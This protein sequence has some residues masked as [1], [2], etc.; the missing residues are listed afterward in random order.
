MELNRKTKPRFFGPMVVVR[1]NR[2]GA[3]ILA[4]LDGAV[5]KLSY[6]AFRVIPYHAR[7]RATI[8]VTKIVRMTEEELD[9]MAKDSEDADTDWEEE[10]RA[11]P[12]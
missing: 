12:A 10:A 5:S 4:E 2:G 7:S 8:P 3:Y 1:R 9:R 11:S 6:A